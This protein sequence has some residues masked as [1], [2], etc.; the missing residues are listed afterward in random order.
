MTLS[1]RRV[2]GRHRV[3]D[4]IHQDVTDAGGR[5]LRDV[6]TFACPDWCNVVAVTPA[7]EIVCIW[8]HRFGTDRLEL[9]IPGGVLEPGEP[10][11]LA[12]ARELREETGYEAERIEPLGL[13]AP[14]PALQGNTCHFFVASGARPTAETQFDEHEDIEVAL[15]PEAHVAELIDRGEIRHSLAIVALER[16]LRTR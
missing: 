3:F 7:R 16:Y 10:P 1:N 15:V 6:F 11:A 2:V 14:N 4:V 5:P 13:A 8:Q 9:E 12:A